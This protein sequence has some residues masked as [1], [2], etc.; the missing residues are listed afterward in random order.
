MYFAPK[1]EIV[2]L[3][4]VSVILSSLSTECMDPEGNDTPI[5]M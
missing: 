3:E 4:L 5:M 1:A 2:D